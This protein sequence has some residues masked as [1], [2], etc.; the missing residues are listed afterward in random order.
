MIT[1]LSTEVKFNTKEQ[2]AL[3]VGD[4]KP[5]KKNNYEI[6]IY[7][8]L[9]MD[10]IKFDKP[11]KPKSLGKL[12]KSIFINDKSCMPKSSK[13]NI[14]HQNYLTAHLSNNSSLKKKL[15]STTSNGNITGHKLKHKT[16]VRAKF[17][18]HKLS[19]LRVN[20]DE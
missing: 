4:N 8:P 6:K 15:T 11:M 14:Y 16:E 7:L 19:Q 18:N 10:G 2:K 9:L 1:V 3:V 20:T 12:N 13:K 17:L 5:N